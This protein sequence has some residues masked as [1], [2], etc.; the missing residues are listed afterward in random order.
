MS[1]SEARG[2]ALLKQFTQQG[3]KQ[4]EITDMMA[5]LRDT[6]S[7]V[8]CVAIFILNKNV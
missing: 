4:M 2:C 3:Q 8:L 6:K 1:G 7:G 5:V